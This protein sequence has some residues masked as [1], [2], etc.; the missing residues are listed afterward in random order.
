VSDAT[1]TQALSVYA[2]MVRQ[3]LDNPQRWLGGDDEPSPD[4]SLPGRVLDAVKD[5]TLGE[6]T[7]GSAE[8]AQQPLPERVDWWVD[9]IGI[10]GGLAAAAPRF[11]GALAD[12][13]PLQAALGAAAAGLAVC[14]V[15]REHGQTS[16]AEWIPLLARVLFNRD[17]APQAAPVPNPEESEQQ[18]E[19]AASDTREPPSKMAALGQG[20][21]RSVRTLWRLARTF[22]GVQDLLDERPRGGFF[23]RALAKVPVV[24][25]AGGWLDERGGIRKAAE[26]TQ[27]LLA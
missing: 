1:L 27:Q 3:V 25:L 18:L 23:A 16:A 19:D 4:A 6:T 12:R 21:Q 11:A 5:R 14:A 15:A 9:R 17:L 13:I 7:P 8:W 24:G 10:V 22:L 20:A 2:G 26:E